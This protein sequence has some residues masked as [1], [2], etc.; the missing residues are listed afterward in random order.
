MFA[1][2]F[3]SNSLPSK[4]IT[5]NLANTMNFSDQ[6]HHLRSDE[7]KLYLLTHVDAY[8]HFVMLSKYKI[9]SIP[10]D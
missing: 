10:H 7:L 6:Q 9:F 3:A 1:T 4:D 8:I 2:L 5:N